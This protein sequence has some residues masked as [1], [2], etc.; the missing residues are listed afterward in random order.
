MR[1]EKHYIYHITHID[2]LHNIIQQGR[3]FSKNTVGNNYI[4]VAH[5]SV[6]Q[7]RFNKQVPLLPYGCLHDYVPFY[8]GMRSPM[9]YVISKGNVE[10]YEGG[11]EEIVYLVSTVEWCH[12]EQLQFVFT[13]GHA[14][15]QLSAFYNNVGDLTE[16]DFEA[17]KERFWFDD[18]ENLDRERQKQSEFLVRNEFPWQGVLGIVTINQTM[19]D[20][21]IAIYDE[22]QTEY[23]PKIA[24]KPEWYY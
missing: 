7:L 14:A 2:N 16:V 17:A 12:T 3:L 18:H 22:L 24:I 5:S 10:G 20:Q 23:R 11:Q 8:F 4:D 6:Q 19:K 1:Q 13:D 9:L 15:V 21:V